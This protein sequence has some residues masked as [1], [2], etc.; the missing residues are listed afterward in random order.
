MGLALDY[1]DLGR[2]AGGLAVRI[3]AGDP[4]GE[5]PVIDPRKTTLILNLRTARRIGVTIPAPV[6]ETAEVLVP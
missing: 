1:R 4:A 2:Q 3:E 5:I 6:Q